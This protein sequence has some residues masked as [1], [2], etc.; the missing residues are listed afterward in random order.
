[1]DLLKLENIIKLINSWTL[2]FTLMLV[3]TGLWILLDSFDIE[4]WGK[5]R[6]EITLI[7][8]ISWLIFISKAISFLFHKHS[9]LKRK[10]QRKLAYEQKLKNERK[11]LL[12]KIQR[13]DDESKSFLLAKKRKGVQMFEVKTPYNSSSVVQRLL[14]LSVLKV[15][16]IDIGLHEI[17]IEDWIWEKINLNLFN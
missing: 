8:A 1:M 5:F 13:L 15:I 14:D 10:K 16:D 2:V 6:G 7:A 17:K 12:K 9:E 11:R 4:S 3:S